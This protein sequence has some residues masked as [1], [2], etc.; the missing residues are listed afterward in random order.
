MTTDHLTTEQ[1]VTSG[2]EPDG[3]VGWGYGVGVRVG[4]GG[5]TEP[6]GR[7]GWD[8]GLGTSWAN[9][10]AA[11]LTGILLTTQMWS[12]PLPPPVCQDFWANAYARILD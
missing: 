9:D 2:P 7:S 11:D 6:V 12:S 4:A 5:P 8:G 1:R 3:Q 10:P